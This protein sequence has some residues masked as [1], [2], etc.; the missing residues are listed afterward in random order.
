MCAPF[1][2]TALTKQDVDKIKLDEQRFE[3]TKNIV[4]V[5]M[6]GS[7][8]NTVG[9]ALAKR[10][11][12]PFL[13]S[14]AE[15]IQASNMTIS[16]I[17]ERFGEVFFREKEILVVRRLLRQKTPCVIATGG[18]VFLSHENRNNISKRGISLYLNV[19]LDILWQRVCNKNTRPLLNS[20]DPFDTFQRLYRERMSI[21]RTADLMISEDKEVEIDSVVDQVVSVLLTHPNVLIV[22]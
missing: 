18:G 2:Q 10:L 5:G 9:R 17:F 3:L 4:L 13:D 21:Y 14:D 15:I 22:K 8:K 12:V 11:D 20:T 19:K 16:E 6:M 7:G 1:L